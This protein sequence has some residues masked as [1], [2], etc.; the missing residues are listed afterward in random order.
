MPDEDLS[1]LQRIERK[2]DELSIEFDDHK[3]RHKL[4]M[5]M[6]MGFGKF[7]VGITA[8]LTFVGGAIFGFYKLLKGGA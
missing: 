7:I 4:V 2:I 6:I 8:V 1:A 5:D 3:G